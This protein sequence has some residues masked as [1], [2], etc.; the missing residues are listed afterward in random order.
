MNFF[1]DSGP[2]Y[3]KVDLNDR[4]H[5]ICKKFY[6]KYPLNQHYFCTTHRIANDELDNIRSKRWLDGPNKSQK[7]SRIIEQ[8]ARTLLSQ[9]ADIDYRNS[10]SE[11]STLYN[12][13]HTF[14]DGRKRDTNPKTHDAVLF[15]NA[16]LWDQSDAALV[17][18]IFLTVDKK[19]FYDNKDDLIP[20]AD[21]LLT[22]TVRLN[23][24]LPSDFV[25]SC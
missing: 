22:E 17:N 11:F 24:H 3:G 14:L 9:I 7:V 19:D 4:Y 8:L 25:N 13:I 2:I 23:I 21:A 16:L 5:P 18:P 6:K 10:H 20:Y 1:L 15:T 12:N